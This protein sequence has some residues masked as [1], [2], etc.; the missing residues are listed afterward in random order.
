MPRL[1]NDRLVNAV[2]ESSI[3][4]NNHSDEKKGSASLSCETLPLGPDASRT[5]DLLLR[6]QS[7]YPTELPDRTLHCIEISD[8][9]QA[10]DEICIKLDNSVVSLVQ[11]CGVVG[12]PFL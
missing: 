5:H 12:N 2:Q 8:R 1:S 3:G 6:R 7:L 10:S 11:A 9:E 4:G